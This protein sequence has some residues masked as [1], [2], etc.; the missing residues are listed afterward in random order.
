[1]LSTARRSLVSYKSP[2]ILSSSHRHLLHFLLICNTSLLTLSKDLSTLDIALAPRGRDGQLEL[3]IV[4]AD[5]GGD[6][7]VR[8]GLRGD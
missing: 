1:M 2:Q 5:V 6:K 4:D 8:D 7:G 3:A